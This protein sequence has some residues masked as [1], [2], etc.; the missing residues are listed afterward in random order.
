MKI[1]LLLLCS[2]TL[3]FSACNKDAK[4]TEVIQSTTPSIIDPG[5]HKSFT[6]YSYK[7][8]LPKFALQSDSPQSASILFSLAGNI[9]LNPNNPLISDDKANLGRILFYDKKMSANGEVACASCHI[10]SKAFTDGLDFSKGLQGESTTRSSMSI[11]NLAFINNYFWDSRT[12]SLEALVKQPLLNK[13]EMGNHSMDEVV[14]RLKT[15]SYYPELF[16]NAFGSEGINEASIAKALLHFVQSI[17]SS[18]TKFDKGVEYG[19]QN[20]NVEEIAGMSLFNGKAGCN[21]CH[22]APTFAAQDFVGGAYGQPAG[23]I[24]IKKGPIAEGRTNNGLNNTVSGTDMFKIPTLRNIALTAPYMHDGRFNTISDV[25]EHY[26]HGIVMNPSLD[27]ALMD[28][29]TN[30]PKAKKLNLSTAEK[31]ALKAFLNTLT[32]PELIKASRYSSPFEW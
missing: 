31:S 18:N 27:P 21:H 13:I 3:I 16:Q 2:V 1:N 32:D 17:Y 15:V 9:P 10:Q 6:Y 14:A 28:L 25:I 5:S 4:W 24:N 26:D 7:D 8:Y 30:E 12:Q 19:F 22:T 23:P 11:Q 29:T 20:F